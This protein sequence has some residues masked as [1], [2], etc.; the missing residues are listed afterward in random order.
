MFD[1]AFQLMPRAKETL[2]KV[3]LPKASL[4][5]DFCKEHVRSCDI[6]RRQ[7]T[8][9]KPILVC[10][11]CKVCTLHLHV[12]VKQEKE[13]YLID[14]WCIKQVAVH[15]DCYRTVKASSGPWCC[16]LCEELSLSRGSGVPAVNLVEKSY[17]VAEC[18]L[19]GG[20]T[21]AFRKSSDGQWVHAF[22]AEV[23]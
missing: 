6:C 8:I 19:C 20:T 4:E 21:G 11:S 2:T 9:L 7:E 12:S 17:F 14:R 15:L 3:A 22:C 18:G 23:K 16:E 13:K 1:N 10:S 5:S